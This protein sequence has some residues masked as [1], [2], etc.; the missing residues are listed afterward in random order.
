MGT[1]DKFR[2][3]FGDMAIRS[4]HHNV[5]RLDAARSSLKS[6]VWPPNVVAADGNTLTRIRYLRPN[7]GPYC[8]D[9]CR[10]NRWPR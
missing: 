2:A 3:V 8:S 4:V 6:E 1:I 7:A 9:R 10:L 5:A